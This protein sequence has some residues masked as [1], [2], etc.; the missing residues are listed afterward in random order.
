MLASNSNSNSTLNQL[1]LQHSQLKTL[2]AWPT[3]K[4]TADYGG[5]DQDPAAVQDPPAVDS[6]TGQRAS[7]N[8]S[9]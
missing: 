6:R 2:P 1:N 7:H 4:Y 3:S 9:R 5:E 8:D